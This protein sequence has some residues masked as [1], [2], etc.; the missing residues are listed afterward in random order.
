[1]TRRLVITADDLGRDHAGT[2]A[3]HALHLAGAITRA[4]LI[5]VSPHAAQ[6]VET[7]RSSGVD[8]QLHL[9]LTS[10]AGP[11]PWRPLTSGATLRDEQGDLPADARRVELTAD[12]EQVRAELDAQLDWMHRAG[13]EPRTAD[14][15]AGVLYGLRGGEQLLP[16]VLSWCAEHRLGFRFPREPGQHLGSGHGPGERTRHREAV[17]LADSH[18][19]RLPDALLT[20]RRTTADH[21][22]YQALRAELIDGL[23]RLPEGTSELFLHPSGPG[24]EIPEMRTWEARLLQDP[25]WRRALHTE[26][27]EL[28]EEW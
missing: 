7:F 6:A 2:A 16:M 26:K 13:L 25:H 8:P 4:T 5:P 20:S 21:G 15:H 19:V 23:R 27:I 14:S 10:D 12:P 22:G 17:E 11:G 9:T 3:I 28:V 1:M 24:P 18:G